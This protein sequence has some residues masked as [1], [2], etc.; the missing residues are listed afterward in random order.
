[1][2]EFVVISGKGGT[3]K[4]S[5]VASF[6][7]LFEKK[8]LVDCDVDAANLHLVV[9]TVTRHREQFGGGK[10]ARILPDRCTQCGE[11]QRFC[12]FEA[13][14]ANSESADNE[15][16]FQVDRIS[17]EGCGVCVA[18]CPAD[19]VLFEEAING[20][21]FVSDTRVGPMV[22]ARLGIA[23]GNSG[24]LVSLV[25]SQARGLAV[26]RGLELVLIDGPP[27]I[28]CPV[29]ASIT[30]TDLVLAVTEP[31]LSGLHDLER[32]RELT[33]HFKIKTVACV[34]KYDLNPEMS[35]KIEERCSECGV[36]VVGRI[37]YDNEVT[38]A[39]IRQES[40]VEFSDGPV[41]V[42][43]RRMWARVS[44]IL[45]LDAEEEK[46][47]SKAEARSLEKDR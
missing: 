45:G 33:R 40:I 32:V 42:E 10:K 24:K 19:A 21:W 16:A 36:E 44:E 41:S 47:A 15:G 39:Q 26:K 8:V 6:A 25:R 23:E 14:T 37:P 7:A 27:G 5:I 46:S 35:R 12:R 29:I 13:I 43:I 1:M 9:N 11:C 18:V 38:R 20:E 30:G 28:G 3:G 22:H 31:T 17:C 4:T 2:K 34:N